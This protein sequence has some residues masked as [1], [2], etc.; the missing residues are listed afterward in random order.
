MFKRL[1]KRRRGKGNRFMAC[2]LAGAMVLSGMAMTTVVYAD[3]LPADESGAAADGN[4]TV[5][6]NDGITLAGVTPGTYEF[7][8]DEI[9][10]AGDITSAMQVGTENYFTL[11]ATSSATFTY[12]ASSG[13]KFSVAGA[14][15][16]TTGR[17]KSN[18]VDNGA[19]R[20]I[21][22]TVPDGLTADVTLCVLSSNS[23]SG[24]EI[25]LYKDG[26]I[27]DKVLSM[28]GSGSYS[29]PIES[30]V[31]ENIGSG[32]FYITNTG[33]G[34]K[35]ANFF[36]I[37]VEEKVPGAQIAPPAA[38]SVDAVIAADNSN[39]AVVSFS[40][41]AGG[42][43]S[44]YVVEASKTPNEEDSWKKV[45]EAEGNSTAG[46]VRVTLSALGTG[47]WYFRVYGTGT[48]SNDSAAQ[49][50]ASP[51]EYILP[52]GT[53]S[54][55]S[56]TPGDGKATVV[57]NAVAEATGYQ[58]TAYDAENGGNILSQSPEI[59]AVD[60]QTSYT[61]DLAGLTNGAKYYLEVTAVRGQ[62]K[63]ASARCALRPYAPIDTSD[64]IP[65]LSIANLDGAAPIILRQDGDITVSQAKT[66]GGIK[67]NGT[68]TD[69]SILYLNAPVAAGTD[70]SI[71]AEATITSRT[72]TG[73]SG[74]VFVG[75]FTGVD[76]N[77]KFATIAMRGDKTIR[78][79][80]AKSDGSGGGAGD[81][82]WEENVEYTLVAERSG[83]NYNFTVKKGD[84]ILYQKT[85]IITEL[86][87]DLVNGNVYP[88][89][90]ICGVTVK[91]Q[92]VVITVG[93]E[94]KFDSATLTGSVT[95]FADNWDVADTP[96][97]KSVAVDNAAQ[98]ITV[99]C[100]G[101]VGVTGAAQI[102]VDMYNAEG[103]KVGSQSS[104][105]FGQNTHTL[106]FAPSSSG[107]YSFVATASRPGVESVKTSEQVTAPEG[108]SLT[109]GGTVV[110]AFNKGSGT[111]KLNWEAVKEA[112]GY[113]VAYK[114]KGSAD[115]YTV[116]E[117]N[118]QGTTYTVTG[119]ADGVE[120][121]FC[122]K[123]V[124]G[125]ETAAADSI[126]DKTA[127][128]KSEQEWFFAAFGSSTNKM[129]E[130]GA[131]NGFSG[132]VAGNDLSVWEINGKGKL[133]PNSTDGIAFY[134]T[135]I[136]PATENFTFSADVIVD[137]WTY[138][139]GQEG[140]GLMAADRVGTNGDSAAFWNNSYMAVISKV[141]FYWDSSNNTVSD[142]GTKYT[143]RLGVGAQ[144]KIGVT[145]ESLIQDNAVDFFSS[146]MTALDARAA[147]AGLA[148]GD[149]NMV[150]GVTNE[151]A[152]RAKAADVGTLQSR[153]HLE[154]QRNN[155]GY[156]VSYTDENGV[157]TTK[158]Y[159]HG[160]EG[161]ELTKLDPD[162]I[163]L[164]FFAAR[165]AKIHVEN[166]SLTTIRP[167]DDAPAESRPL[168]YVTPNYTVESSSISNSSSY[169]IVYYGNADGKLTIK[170]QNGEVLADAVD[171][172]ANEKFRL[173][174]ALELGNNKF[175][176]TFT[177]NADYCP[178][179]YERLSS[180][181]TKNF[182]FTV[183]YQKNDRNV[184]YVSPK[185]NGD[186]S[187]DNPMNIYEAV[188]FVQPGSMIVLMEG[189]YA[190]NRT[191]TVERGINGTAKSYIYMIT[192]PEASTRP[193][194]DFG[195][196]CAGM[197]LAGDYWYFQGFDVTNSAPG[198]KGVQVSGDHNVLDDLMT[199]KN[200][201]TG[202]QISRYLGTDQWEDWPSDNLILNCTSYLN[203]DP[204]YEDAD[205]F[206]AKLTIADGNVF[207]GCISAYNADDGWDLF[208][209]IET[210]PIGKV[211]I[212]NSVAFKNG[213]VIGE[214]GNEIV[215]GNGNGFKMG[216]ESITGYHTLINSV[217]FANRA[218]GIDS[219]SCPDIQVYNS[220]SFENESYNVAFYTN[221]AANTDFFAEGVLS[222]KRNGG[223]AEQ[224]KLKGSQDTA[225]V[226]KAL[227]YFF[228]GAVSQN[229]EGSTVE[230]GWF[231]SLDTNAA[232]H[233]G[234]SR[235]ADGTINMNGYLV[236][237]D[238]A[239]KGAGAAMT[240]TPSAQI[241][242]PAQD[243]GGNN[244]NNNADNGGNSNNN[245]D[246]NGGSDNNNSDSGENNTAEQTTEQT[247]TES[248]KPASKPSVP[249]ENET[250]QETG[251]G[252]GKKL[253]INENLDWDE[254]YR[255]LE[256]LLETSGND[257]NEKTVVEV[258]LG[259]YY[260]LPKTIAAAIYG[261]DITLR[262]T[263]NNGVVWEVL[264][265]D[266]E[267]LREVN[268]KVDLDSEAIPEKELEIFED[269]EETMQFSL[270]HDGEF[271]FK[272]TLQFP[273]GEK[274]NG[275][276][277]N[278]FYYNAGSFEFMGTSQ[279]SEGM[280]T[281]EFTHASD[282]VL[283]ISEDA[284]KAVPEVETEAPGEKPTT[285]DD[286]KSQAEE[287]TTAPSPSEPAP[288]NEADNGG[289]NTLMIVLI[290]LAVVIAAAAAAGV[291]VMHKKKSNK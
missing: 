222:Y 255:V 150:A 202:I 78:A 235:N 100:D 228:D 1:L 79:Y 44:K 166:V 245:N 14:T 207:D 64:A 45:G 40:G 241:K 271:G 226:Y 204:G 92:N 5:P 151:D 54:I 38:S 260:E 162:N 69:M 118:A 145:Q 96:V 231:V 66:S 157:T 190:L 214:D 9:G 36:Y 221:N 22:F 89:I 167:E 250:K 74:G 263:Q 65:G 43:G 93:G 237:T 105:A 59:A 76:G 252:T 199:Y 242:L 189:T 95:P 227:N 121:T 175:D 107:V 85:N 138:S 174:A 73:S 275:K 195:K 243:N 270:A 279:V 20:N 119:L 109:L 163:Y 285:N 33:T 179:K 143:M 205:G 77:S 134:Y 34:A 81:K 7:K 18:K 170:R 3:E 144:E 68:I 42:E 194:L 269:A 75:G 113:Q 211:V 11:N 55:K 253:I 91:L 281:F 283:V 176:V 139:N 23:T 141:D 265:T 37:K 173:T 209:K 21:A 158:K 61:Y 31:W 153:F 63:T 177:P 87:G 126:V 111:V 102:V 216:G 286:K 94:K 88:A 203:A 117:A 183:R 30:T 72:N 261:K 233:G 148:S 187:K 29:Q 58:V 129:A 262:M 197:V 280:A 106:T 101:E 219:N 225:K 47:D 169:E 291:V 224:M 108:F 188:K 284:M 246:N 27:T 155:T 159:Y 57:W 28:E 232:I 257:K 131:D 264:G 239:V 86:Y 161:D 244:N 180:Y 249:K 137:N 10:T 24:M 201:N 80:R 142:A 136:N 240:G 147:V 196:A 127:E 135:T 12:E 103:Q 198:Q 236:L 115:E 60:G 13:K 53:P 168:T 51:L 266:I 229:S 125:S 178:S 35:A 193:V 17:L 289:G 152:L 110:T 49:I 238:G 254:V 132:S 99:V 186:G 213:Y 128:N 130:N 67:S 90:A 164:G 124:R 210:G 84:E 272:A 112:T 247:G 268:M 223:V 15:L 2:L 140:F 274:N 116:A 267:R 206:A 277:A 282:Y 41:T 230:D 82:S 215:A 4:V 220:T 165:N 191:L 182:G 273:A 276:Y 6:G 288:E 133:V 104:A 39:E 120:Y 50:T 19:S 56:T 248:S 97:I 156:F 171:V 122:V 192:D 212:K 83:E 217:A 98:T 62:E 123:A 290:I 114:V 234:I 200:G 16:S 25:A 160:D 8:V 149:Y 32:N 52:F 256:E 71:T 46:E 218:K 154:I 146:K 26:Q 184:I 208:A 181:D 185:G 48:G 258:E 259:I 287:E 70:F 172:K 251:N 278:L